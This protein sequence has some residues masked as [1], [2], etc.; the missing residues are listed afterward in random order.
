MFPVDLP[1][2]RQDHPDVVAQGRQG[3]REAAR[4]VGE[5]A[6]LRERGDL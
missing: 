2:P 5:A 1:V 6:G 4:D 3:L